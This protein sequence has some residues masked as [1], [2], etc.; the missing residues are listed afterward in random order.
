MKLPEKYIEAMKKLLGDEFN[1][2]LECM[3]KPLRHGLRINTR[4]IS[5]EDFLKISPFNLKPVPWCSNGF[6]YD[7]NIYKP[8]KHPYYYAGLYYLQEPSA[9]LPASA[10][11]IEPEDRV[12]DM[13]AA[14]GGKSTELASKLNGTGILV[15]NDISASRAKA[16]LKNLELFGTENVIVTCEAPNG[17]SKKF[18]KYFDKILIDAPCSGE[19][20]FRKSSAMITAWEQNGNEMFA[21]IQRGIL[22]E[23]VKMLK[24]GGII[25]YSTCTFSPLEDE[26]SVEY[27]LSLDSSLEVIDIKKEKGFKDGYPEFSETKNPDLIKCARLFPHRIEGEGHFVAL[28]KNMEV[29][30][31]T[32]H[33]AHIIKNSKITAEAKEFLKKL[34]LKLDLSRVEVNN[35]KLYYLP[36]GCPDTDGL[37]ILRKGLFLGKMKK[38]R[39]EPSQ[40]LAMSLDMKDYDNCLSLSADD[41]RVVRYLKGETI[42]AYDSDEKLSDG[43]VL[44]CVSG[45]PLGWGKS[46]NNIIKNKY[47]PGWRM[48]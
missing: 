42:E 17:L 8:S 19:G 46:K 44:I 7:E 33:S 29:S 20:M 36:V 21:G 22:N 6:Y 38:N 11:P 32:Y 1:D 4:K 9:M 2:Y 34:K 47:L 12:L 13:C 16:L 25:L 24:P 31:E 23:A 27:L 3:D 10:L 18:E 14:P 39:F 30:T 15:S 40:A 28:I 35:E 45:Y 5:V 26:K 48:M 43:Y 37:R 41:E